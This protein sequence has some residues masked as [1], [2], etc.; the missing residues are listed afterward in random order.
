MEM[1]MTDA[2]K[3]KPATEMVKANNAHA[4][5]KRKNLGQIPIDVLTRKET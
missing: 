1:T 4:L 5:N 2:K 3:L